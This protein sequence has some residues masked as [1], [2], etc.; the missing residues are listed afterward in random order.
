MAEFEMK[1]DWV[2]VEDYTKDP[3]KT[4]GGIYVAEG[5]SEDVLRGRV[6]AVGPG[7]LIYE[8]QVVPPQVDVGAYVFYQDVGHRFVHQGKAYRA[9]KEEDIICIVRE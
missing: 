3:T 7:K 8:G 6:V 1:W 2:A 5:M 4:P 9:I